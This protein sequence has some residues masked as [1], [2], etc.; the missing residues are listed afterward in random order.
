MFQSAALFCLLLAPVDPPV[1][2]VIVLPMVDPVP[3]PAPQPSPVSKLGPNVYYVVYSDAPF[4]VQASPVGIVSVTKDAGPLR[5]RGYFAE[6]PTVIQTKTFTAKNL[7]FVDALATGKCELLIWPTGATGDGQVIRRCLD[8]NVLPIPPP[9][10]PSP[11]IPPVPVDEFTASVQA[12]YA[13]ET[14]ANKADDLAF[15]TA[16]YK[17]AS[18]PG[19]LVYLPSLASTADLLTALKAAIGYPGVGL[20]ATDLVKVRTAI[21]T[22]LNKTLATPAPLTDASRVTIAALFNKVANALGGVK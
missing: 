20:A 8:V 6:A 11:P 19:G 22:E 2:P 5:V 9:A 14:Q 16:V 15:L 3:I 17:A 21:A 12:A 1:T 13:A 18:Q 4:M 7:A 10:P